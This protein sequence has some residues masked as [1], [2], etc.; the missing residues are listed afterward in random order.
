M[1]Q[2]KFTKK[3]SKW[4]WDNCMPIIVKNMQ[5]IDERIKGFEKR[6]YDKQPEFGITW[7][8]YI[9]FENNDKD[10]ITELLGKLIKLDTSKLNKLIEEEA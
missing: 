8:D 2:V 10:F 7:N 5:E 3:E 1:N 9:D 4:L 6:K